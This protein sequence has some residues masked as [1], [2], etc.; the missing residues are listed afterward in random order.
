MSD[1]IMLIDSD[2]DEPVLVDAAAVPLAPYTLV[3]ET[4]DGVIPSTSRDERPGQSAWA[5]Q[6][7]YAKAATIVSLAAMSCGPFALSRYLVAYLALWPTIWLAHYRILVIALSVACATWAFMSFNA[8]LEPWHMKRR[9]RRQSDSK[10]GEGISWRSTTLAVLMLFAI[11]YYVGP[12]DSC[13]P[14]QL[15]IFIVA[16][17]PEEPVVAKIYR[18]RTYEE[19]LSLSQTDDYMF[20]VG[21]VHDECPVPIS[22]RYNHTAGAATFSDTGMSASFD[23]Q[24]TMNVS[25]PQYGTIRLTPTDAGRALRDTSNFGGGEVVL[26]TVGHAFRNCKTLKLSPEGVPRMDPAHVHPNLKSATFARATQSEQIAVY[27]VLV[28]DWLLCMDHELNLLKTPGFSP[29]KAVYALCRYSALL[30]GAVT[31][32]TQVAAPLE[33]CP[34]IFQLPLY[35]TVLNVSLYIRVTHVLNDYS[36]STH[37]F[38]GAAGVLIVRL[39]AFTG[40]NRRIAGFMLCCIAAVLSYQLWVVSSQIKIVEGPPACFPVDKPKAVRA[41]SGFF[42]APLLFDVTATSIFVYHGRRTNLRLSELSGAVRVFIKEGAL[43]FIAIST[44]NLINAVLNFQGQKEYSG[45]AVPFHMIMPNVL[46]CRL[47]I[48][49]RSST[50]ETTLPGLPS[51]AYSTAMHFTNPKANAARGRES[52]QRVSSHISLTALGRS[53]VEG[54]TIQTSSDA[55]STLIDRNR[56]R[57]YYTEMHHPPPRYGFGNI[58]RSARTNVVD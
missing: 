43:Y 35:F 36:P 13:A 39:Y 17:S 3:K 30:S 44:I 58:Q 19:T 18:S 45:L 4:N 37:K 12:Y 48:N 41:L 38:S 21:R 24:G 8:V 22:V 54:S 34:R 42:L 14:D 23:A 49:L 53:A 2:G 16:L 32:W 46:A 56:P 1:S 31:V 7:I 47:V 51:G 27:C 57:A 15:S 11:W 52:E 26:R 55:P 25:L 5:D 40:S 20:T 29:A 50:H 33:L 28:F 9:N 6:P 10:P